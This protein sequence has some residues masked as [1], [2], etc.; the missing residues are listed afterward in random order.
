VAET[1]G[2]EVI[3]LQLVDPRFYHLDTC[4]CPLAEDLVA[5]F[6]PAFD[7]YAQRAIR[8]H[9]PRSIELTE[10]D[11]LRFAANAVPINR[12]VALNSGC[13]SFEEDLEAHGYTPHATDLSQFLRAGG[14]AKCLVL[15]APPPPN[16]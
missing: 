13:D 12:H 6:P 11:A 14:S 2:V 15:T 4:F 3:S 5:W 8:A 1:F 16:L 10:P 9:L 7:E